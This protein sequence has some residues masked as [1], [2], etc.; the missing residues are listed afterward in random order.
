MRTMREVLTVQGRDLEPAGIEDIRR[1]I[2]ENPAW[3]RWRLSGQLAAQWDWRNPGGQLKDMAARSLLVKLD[4]RG[5]IELPPRRQ[6]PVNR[7]NLPCTVDA[8]WD[9]TPVEATLANAGPLSVREISTERAARARCAAALSRFHYLG[10]RGTVGENLQYE[11]TGEAGRLLGCM[12]FGSAAW[13]CRSRDEFIGWNAE[14]K[15]GRLDRITNNTRFLILP[16]VQVPHL[17][18]WILGQTLRRLSADWEKKYAH[19]ILL[20]ET[21]VDRERFRG[22]CYRAANWI[23]TGATAGRSRQDRN[24][25]LRVPIKDVYVY[26]LR[27]RFR[28][29]L[30]S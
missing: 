19:P 12:V 9:E 29:E 2:A 7:M 26:P 24:H 6:T 4:A 15:R 13:S 14:Q 1:L 30:S 17:A 10:W 22:T 8:G 28:Q 16:F 23:H 11:I 27:R 18:S 25:A 5:L 3:S 21:F 20:V